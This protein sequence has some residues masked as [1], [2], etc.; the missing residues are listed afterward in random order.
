MTEISPFLAIPESSWIASSP[1]SFAIADKFPVSEGHALVIPKRVVSTWWELTALEQHDLIDLVA[2][3]KGLLDVR[4]NPDGYN[5]GFNSGTA[6]G[7]TVDHV[8]V[9][10]IPRLVGDVP[11]PTGG[12]R[13]VIPGKANYLAASQ[14][15]LP[16]AFPG[17]GLIDARDDRT[18]KLEIY[19]ALINEEFDRA[20]FLVSFIMESGL[21]LVEQQLD[22]AL[23]RGA[24]IRILT[25]DYMGVT[26]PAALS[27]LLDLGSVLVNDESR[28]SLELR[29]FHD[30]KTSFHPKAY[31]FWSAT[32]GRG[33]GF[34]GSNN[35]SR[36][37][38]DGG[39]EWSTQTNAIAPLLESFDALWSDPRSLSIDPTWINDYR[40][41]RPTVALAPVP[42]VEDP[43]TKTPEPRPTQIEALAALEQT[44][45]DGFRAGLVVMATG[46]GKTLLA[47]FDTDRPEFER[48]LFVAHREEILNQARAALR[49]VQP[50]ASLG[51]FTGKE[52]IADGD[53]TF[54]TVQTMSKHVQDFDPSAFDYVVID[55]FHHAAAPS[56]RTVI[57]HFTP[58]FL[59]GLTATPSRMDNADLLALCGDNLVFQCDLI[60]GIEREELVPFKY[61]GIADTI[62]F[63]PIPWRNGRFDPAALE[64]AAINEGRADAALREWER[65]AGKRTL[66]FCV[67]IKHAEYMA[68]HFRNRGIESMALHSGSPASA[69]ARAIG[70]LEGG[71]LAVL[72]TVDLFN[73]GIDMPMLD[74]VLMLRPTQ[75]PVVFLQQIGRGLRV[76]DGK[77]HLDIVDFVG[78][79]RSFLSPLRTLLSLR[80]GRTPTIGELRNALKD[81]MSI[82]P[83][84]CSV[85]YDLGAIELLEALLEERRGQDVTDALRDIIVEFT[86]EHGYR[87]SALQTE[88]AGG[89]VGA[90]RKRSSS[91]FDLLAELQLLDEA[92]LMALAAAGDA[93]RIVETT[94]M[95]RSFKMLVLQTMLASG[96]LLTGAS[97]PE[98][99]ARSLAL[100]QSDPRLRADIDSTRFPSLDVVDSS[101]WERYWRENP[102]NAWAGTPSFVLTHDRLEP[103]F[104]IG[105]DGADAFTAMTAEL[106]EWRLHT[107]FLRSR[108]QGDSTG[109]SIT[110]SVS[111][112][113]GAPIVRFDRKKSP[114]VPLGDQVFLADGRE[115]TGRFV[116]IALNVANLRGSS[117]N[118]LPS[119]LRGWFGPAAGHPGSNHEVRLSFDDG[120][121]TME[122]LLAD[123]GHGVKGISFF[124]DY[125]VACGA[126]DTA[127]ALDGSQ[128]QIP[129]KNLAQASTN[130]FV[131]CVRGDS[132]SGEPTSLVHGDLARLR[133][134]EGQSIDSLVGKPVLVELSDSGENRAALKLLVAGPTGYVLRS[135]SAG[136]DDIPG[137]SSMRVVGEFIE[138]IDP[139]RYDP[140][141]ALLGKSI[142]REDIAPYFG[143]EFNPGNWQSGHVLVTDDDLVIFVTLTKEANRKEEGYLDRFEDRSTFHWTSQASTVPE[144]KKGRD[145]LE[146]LSSGR[147]IHLFVRN[148]RMDVAFTYAGLVAPLR[149]EGSKPMVVWFRLLTELSDDMVSAL[150]LEI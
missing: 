81:P 146:A 148:K 71:E 124:P 133:W 8:H 101:A 149:H 35:L 113:S 91:W 121:W 18:L 62:D 100:V 77:T 117:T 68:A 28:N 4:L 134:V 27:R 50:G 89:N 5:V 102:I 135:T 42:D 40:E 69:R 45:E 110:M 104:S 130:E 116:K 76:A 122:P 25:T 141:T 7:Q 11:D 12:V 126:F 6:A 103:R 98:V 82:L 51:F 78:N 24:H 32:D 65:R 140:A 150:K 95:T 54:A 132:M 26:H 142:R 128:R 10:V 31:I 127:K 123:D 106:V 9:H 41:R 84:G 115:Y 44:R 143:A 19:R 37:G 137:T 34:V 67:S 23:N 90:A 114:N 120:V 48:I 47:A 43:Q 36:S 145:V 107:Y 3:V 72:F 53:I 59:L 105:A 46:L 112:S 49:R 57:D 96:T 136:F 20:D 17:T 144:S 16:F 74:T 86:E 147:R 64:L 111:H 14:T 87:P 118:D 125:E 79:H 109:S 52:K 30:A 131:V 108:S 119:L 1:F 94:Q 29:V 129:I 88:L 21:N 75:S 83:D 138:R 60:A 73:E 33:T 93:L 85:D 97:I 38:I 13:G 2:V 56:Y 58:K 92:E 15:D 139:I 66:A 63:D 70:Q 99:A 80:L 61:W 39:V 55:E 22:A